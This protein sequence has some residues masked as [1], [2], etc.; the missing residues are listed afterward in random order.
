LLSQKNGVRE[1]LQIQEKS[2]LHFFCCPLL[3]FKKSKTE[4]ALKCFMYL[5]WLKP[6]INQHQ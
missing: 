1:N 6:Q 3:S 5:L 2:H 4:A